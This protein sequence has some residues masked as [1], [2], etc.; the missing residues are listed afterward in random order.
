MLHCAHFCVSHYY[1]L[2]RAEKERSQYFGEVNDLR[3]SLD[4]LANEKVF[5][6]L[7][8]IYHAKKLSQSSQWNKSYKLII[9]TH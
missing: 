8:R 6:E 4:Q 9:A 7:H 5:L 3:H 2:F 1:F